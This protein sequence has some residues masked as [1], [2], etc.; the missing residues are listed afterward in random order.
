M[1]AV[2]LHREA[3]WMFLVGWFVTGDGRRVAAL[4]MASLCRLGF[5]LRY[6]L[7]E[8]LDGWEAHR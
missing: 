6:S 2:L 5:D 3:A 4:P 7:G 8:I 1:M